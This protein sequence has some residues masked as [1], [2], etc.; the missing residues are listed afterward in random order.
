MRNI[1]KKKNVNIKT[2]RQNE[3]F[4]EIRTSL[5]IQVYLLTTV[6]FLRSTS[7]LEH[8]NDLQKEHSAILWRKNLLSVYFADF[9][10]VRRVSSKR[11]I[12][13]LWKTKCLLEDVFS[14]FRAWLTRRI[15]IQSRMLRKL[16]QRSNRLPNKQCAVSILCTYDQTKFYIFENSC[17]KDKTNLRIFLV[18]CLVI[19]FFKFVWKHIFSSY[20]K[21]SAPALMVR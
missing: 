8:A 4:W 17:G 15:L 14:V 13:R 2:K 9:A 20:S 19:Y 18:I 3:K 5:I 6:V 7:T 11:V 10:S 1:Y 16:W 12:L 21:I